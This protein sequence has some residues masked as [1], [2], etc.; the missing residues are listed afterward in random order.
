MT[1]LIKSGLFTAL[2]LAAALNVQAQQRTVVTIDEPPAS[3]YAVGKAQVSYYRGSNTTEVRID[4]PFYRLNGQAAT[5]WFVS[6]SE[7]KQIVKTTE[8][9][10][11]LGFRSDKAKL[12]KLAG[13]V[14]SA[15]N[16][17]LNVAIK[18]I[19]GITFELDHNEWART[20]KGVLS[21][22]DFQKLALSKSPRVRVADFEF[23]MDRARR[24]ALQDM[25]KALT[26]PADCK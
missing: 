20:I 10:V 15:D 18:T 23:E 25:L 6:T 16:E 14:L 13:F 1:R 22:D 7:G 26:Q 4:L 19:G 11:G 5:L 8:L 3:H 9:L 2:A 24:A 12:Q 17:P 21:F